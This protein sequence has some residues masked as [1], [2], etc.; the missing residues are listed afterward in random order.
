MTTETLAQFLARRMFEV[1]S[2]SAGR[3]AYRIEFKDADEIGLGGFTKGPFANFLHREIERY[4]SAQETSPVQAV[5]DRAAHLA[6]VPTRLGID[7]VDGTMPNDHRDNIVMD[8][9]PETPAD[10]TW[11]CSICNLVNPDDATH[12]RQC[13]YSRMV[14]IDGKQVPRYSR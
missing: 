5:C 14:M 4:N 13:E 10:P 3:G 12:C 9:S 6:D 1:G 2:D 8:G 7:A 11:R